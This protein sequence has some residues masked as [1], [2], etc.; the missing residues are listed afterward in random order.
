MR[1]ATREEKPVGDTRFPRASQFVR[2]GNGEARV[3]R[4]SEKCP[5]L[6][7]DGKQ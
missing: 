4:V 2:L 3:N 6:P 1:D 7:L 5:F